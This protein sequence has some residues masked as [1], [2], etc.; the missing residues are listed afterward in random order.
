MTRPGTKVAKA[1]KIYLDIGWWF[2]AAF[3]L[4]L[5]PIIGLLLVADL[6]ISDDTTSALPVL[7][8]LAPDEA[9]LIPA[10]PGAAEK[11]ST[12]IDGQGELR[13]R[14]TSLLAWRLF[15]AWSELI[16]IAIAYVHWQLRRVF[17][18][19]LQGQPF[20]GDNAWR[21]RRVGLVMV[22]WALVAPILEYIQAVLTLREVRVRGLILS[23]PIDIKL[24]LFFAGL[25]VVV[26]AEIFRQAS[27]LQ[28]DQS[29][30]V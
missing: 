12:L 10:E 20:A 30:T 8:R 24:E 7:V 28:R 18:N 6:E 5:M 13:F 11:W 26:L 27:D 3:A 22:G 4:V 2:F 15:V 19:V 14:T 29:L 16:F 25:A 17:R 9:S 21:I 1:V 23:P